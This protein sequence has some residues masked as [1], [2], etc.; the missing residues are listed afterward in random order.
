MWIAR[1]CVA[2][3][4]NRSHGNG[5]AP[6]P[7]LGANAAD[8]LDLFFDVPN[9]PINFAAVGFELSLTGAACADAARKL[10]HLNSASAQPRQQVFQLRQF[11]LQLTFTGSRM[12]GK[13]VENKLGAINDPRLDNFLDVALLRGGEIVVKE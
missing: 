7:L 5:L 4:C 8:I 3:Q 6:L 12:S 13:N 1:I 2:D 10:R 9:S 11:H